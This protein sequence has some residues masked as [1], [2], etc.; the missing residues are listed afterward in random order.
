MI[1]N[2]K[3]ILVPVDGSKSSF[4]AARYALNVA[5]LNNAKITLL[6]VSIIPQFP[7]YFESLERYE[8][9]IRRE[10][11]EWFNTIKRFEEA[12]DVEI[13][14]VVNTTALSIVEGIVQVAEEGKYDLIIISPRGKSMIKRLLLGSVTSGVVTYATCPVLVVR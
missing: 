11:S 1:L 5:K 4:E 12:K 7:R 6:Y 8:A 9:E 3:K 13:E 14:E 10:A 2:I